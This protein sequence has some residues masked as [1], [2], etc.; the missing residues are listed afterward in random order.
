MGLR[1]ITSLADFLVDTV[2]T[3]IHGP[4]LCSHD[5]PHRR[6][7]LDWVQ[8]QYYWIPEKTNFV[9]GPANPGTSGMTTTTLN[10][11]LSSAARMIRWTRALAIRF[12]TGPSS[13]VFEILQDKYAP[14]QK[15]RSQGS[16]NLQELV[17]YQI[18]SYRHHQ[19]LK[20]ITDQCRCNALRRWWVQY[21]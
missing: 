9:P 10:F 15:S 14:A 21:L 11:V 5:Y 13:C 1:V 3:T 20:N 7:I 17:F 18:L 8:V 19:S 12:L 6:L 4:I 2:T 16:R